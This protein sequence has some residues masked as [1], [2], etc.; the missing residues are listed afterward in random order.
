MPRA[1][2]K[3]RARSVGANC[4][5]PPDKA[6]IR[7]ASVLRFDAAKAGMRAPARA[8]RARRGDAIHTLDDGIVEIVLVR[9]PAGGAFLHE[10]PPIRRTIASGHDSLSIANVAVC[11]SLGR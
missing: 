1:R 3:R 11:R 8:L 2:R 10:L 9:L 5:E 7:V 6:V 4:S